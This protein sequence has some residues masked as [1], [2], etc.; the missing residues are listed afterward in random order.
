MI[1]QLQIY[2]NAILITH[3]DLDGAVCEILV[4]KAIQIQKVYLCDYKDVNETVIK[5]IEN[6]KQQRTYSPIVITDISVTEE[7]AKILE[8]YFTFYAP[9]IL[10]D[11]HKTAL[12]LNKYLWAYVNTEHSA[13]RLVYDELLND[14]ECLDLMAIAND[15]DMWLHKYPQSKKLN[16]LYYNID[17]ENFINRFLF[18]ASTVFTEKEEFLI[19]TLENKR[20]NYINKMV[21]KVKIFN[22]EIKD[23]YYK[24]GMVI[25]DSEIS[26][27]GEAILKEYQEIDL[28]L[29]LNLTN[30][31]ASVRSRPN[32]DCSEYAK[33]FGGGGHAQA[34][35]F[36]LVQ[37]EDL[38]YLLSVYYEGEN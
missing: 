24:I 29:I 27:L 6:E 18:N 33:F 12:F 21:T 4:K 1:K 38:M 14:E 26:E 20:Q 8:N 15:Y 11:H 25:A 32:I 17:R 3:T 34:S 36:P 28:A 23:K 10:I 37:I 30:E 16:L 22:D 35:G 13:S 9:I 31:T 19:T 7:T 5:I 2:D